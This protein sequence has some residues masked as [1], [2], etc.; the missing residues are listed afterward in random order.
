MWVGWRGEKRG[1][2]IFQEMSCCA[3]LQELKEKDEIRC[4]DVACGAVGCTECMMANLRVMLF[5]EHQEPQ[6]MQKC[7]VVLSRAFLMERIP[8]FRK[9]YGVY[10]KRRLRMIQDGLIPSSMESVVTFKRMRAEE[11]R[12]SVMVEGRNKLKK[13]YDEA[14]AEATRGAARVKSLRMTSGIR[15]T[16]HDMHK[17]PLCAEFIPVM[18]VCPFCACDV[19]NWVDLH[20]VK[21]EKP[22]P[23]VQQVL[24]RCPVAECVGYVDLEGYCALCKSKTCV[25]CHGAC[26]EGHRCDPAQVLSVQTI[27]KDSKL[28]PNTAC[29]AA[30]MR[31]D[32]CT[33]MWCLLCGTSFDWVTLEITDAKHNPEMMKFRKGLR[34]AGI[35]PVAEAGCVEMALSEYEIASV[36]TRFEMAGLARS[37]NMAVV[38]AFTYLVCVLR[39]CMHKKEMKQVGAEFLGAD[40]HR[41]ARLQ[42]M[43]GEMKEAA[44]TDLVYRREKQAECEA[45]LN[46]INNTVVA[47]GCDILRKLRAHQHNGSMTSKLVDTAATSIRALIEQYNTAVSAVA[48][49]FATKA[50]VIEFVEDGRKTPNAAS[51]EGF[52]SRAG[53]FICVSSYKGAV[54]TKLH[55]LGLRNY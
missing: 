21:A 22:T 27:K 51:V 41:E 44:F 26:E 23:R 54:G 49:V 47:V 11:E 25:V 3:C 28:C 45:E 16:V 17:C 55:T 42:F 39:D 10:Q 33:A 5:E 37:V 4:P 24:C 6:C 15:E 8:S 38:C 19:P 29:G 53:H 18:P 13:Q 32:G 7:G 50:N 31:I 52:I 36:R 9:E 30:I 12:T 48:I 2:G 46:G 34:E 40:M 14:C 43:V 1:E 35:S 20:H